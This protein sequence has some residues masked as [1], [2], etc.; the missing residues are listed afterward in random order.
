MVRGLS[1][2][3]L[4]AVG[5]T[6]VHAQSAIS[7]RQEAMK[8]IAGASKL[9]GAVL[10]GQAEFDLT[11]IHGSLAI[12]Q[13]EAAKLKELWPED[14]KSGADTAALPAIWERRNDF[15]ALFDKL[16]ADAKIATEKIKDEATFKAEFPKVMSNCGGCHKQYR[17]PQ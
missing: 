12:Y 11:K 6:A 2:L 16:A 1:I 15:I 5:A 9:P 4:V 8:A 10:K 7:Q 14:S 3:A 17:K 13:A